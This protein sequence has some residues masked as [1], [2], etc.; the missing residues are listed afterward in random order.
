MDTTKSDPQAA[1]TP[2]RISR[3]QRRR[4]SSAPPYSSVRWFMKVMAN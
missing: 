2:S 1:F 4:F 3:A